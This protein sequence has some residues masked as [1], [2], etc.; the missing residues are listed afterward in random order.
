MNKSSSKGKN[1]KRNKKI[2][3]QYNLKGNITIKNVNRYSIENILL[4]SANNVT[5]KKIVS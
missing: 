5:N 2:V 4:S 3:N 1:I